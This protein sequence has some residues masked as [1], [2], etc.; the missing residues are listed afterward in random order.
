MTI[1]RQDRKTV[2]II[3]PEYPPLTNWGGVAT[4]NKSLALILTKLDYKVVVITFD[5]VGNKLKI[6]K[7]RRITI[8][9]SPLKTRSKVFNV[10]Y[11]RFPFG[12]LRNLLIK[13]FPETTFILD[14]NIFSFITFNK[15]HKRFK[16]KEIHAPTYQTPSFLINLY[17]RTIPCILYAQG[18]Q[19]L[20][21]KYETPSRG[22]IVNGYLEKIY[23]KKLNRKVISCS[24]DTKKRIA[25]SLPSIA[26]KISAFPNFIEMEKFR[27]KTKI[28]FKNIV[29]WGRLDHRKGVDILLKVFTKLARKDVDLNLYLIG[30]KNGDFLLNKKRVNYDNYF[31]S[32]NIPEK[33]R[34]RIHY[35]PRIDEHSQLVKLLTKIKGIAVFPSRY[36]PF[37]FVNIEALA[38]GF[39]VV[40][41]ANGGGS[42]IIKNFETGILIPKIDERSLYLAMRKALKLNTKEL[43][44]I[45]LNAQKAVKSNYDVSSIKHS[46]SRII[47]IDS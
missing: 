33:I 36:E 20:S 15:L 47:S 4:F 45:I 10:F 41:S 38:M 43:Q 5:G 29:F 39:L 35:F 30:E 26:N 22:K 18:L 40:T 44:K 25:A 17:H 2:A 32:L 42:E 28:N 12:L 3:S 19:F 13:F 6:I 7:D 24:Q 21:G 11:Y 8:V 14:W 23:L 37:G 46:F 27:N 9:Y 16:F 1:N 34:R 31:S